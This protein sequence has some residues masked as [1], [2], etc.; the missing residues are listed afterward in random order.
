MSGW[1]QEGGVSMSLPADN[2]Q[3]LEA[4]D[5]FQSVCVTA[6]AGSGKTELLSLRVLKLLAIAERPEEILAITFTRKAAAEMHHRIIQALRNAQSGPQPEEAHKLLSWN[7]AKEVL[8]RDEH[9]GW[10]VLDNP[11]RLKIQTIDSLCAN[12]TRQMPILSNFG[13]QPTIAKDAQAHYRQA[14]R[15]LFQYLE[16]DSVL[17]EDLSIL[18]GH[19]DNDMARAERLLMTLLQGRDQWLIHIGADGNPQSAKAALEKT[20]TSVCI[21]LLSKL[22]AE[23]LPM[24]PE[25]LPL[26]DYAGCNIQWQKLNSSISNLAGILELPS[27]STETIDSWL[28]IAELFLTASNS[29]RKTINKNT[30]FPTETEDGDK[31]LA[32]QLKNQFTSHLKELENNPALTALF[33]ELRH[34]PAPQYDQQQ[35]QLLESLTRLL[36]ALVAQLTL[37]FQQHGEVDYSQISMAALQALGENTNPTELA[38]KLDYQLRHILVDEFQDTALTQYRLLERLVEGWEEL[39]VN[40]PDSPNTVFIVGDGMQS[41]YGFR[42]ANVG[43]F[44]EA[45]NN[46]I[47][48]VQLLDLHLTVNFRS[49]PEVVEWINNTFL[50]AFPRIENLARG[51]VPFEP[52]VAYS[53]PNET[54]NISL[55]GFVG[56]HARALEADSVVALVKSALETDP[57]GSIAILVRSRGHLRDILPALKAAEIT[58]NANEIDS[59]ASYGVIIDLLTLTKALFNIADRISWVALLRTPWI[60]LSNKDIFALISPNKD[61]SIY[62]VLTSD[63]PIDSL[64]RHGRERLVNIRGIVQATFESRARL[65]ARDWVEATWLALGGAASVGHHNEFR[66]VDD[67]FDLLEQYQQGELLPSLT[68]FEEAV[69]K[70]YAAP[71][72]AESQLQ[73]MTIHK[74][75]GLEFDTVILPGMARQLRSDEKSL[76]MWR[77]YI[78]TDHQSGMVISPLDAIGNDE[79]AI[80]RHLRYEKTEMDRLEN[81]RLFYVAATRAISKLHVLVTSDVDK[82]TEQPKKPSNNSLI[83]SAWSAL[84]EDVIWSGMEQAGTVD[85]EQFDFSFS[86]SESELTLK[87]LRADW[88]EPEWSFPNPLEAFYLPFDYDFADNTIELDVDILS[89]CVGTIVHW[90][91]EILVEKGIDYWTD[92]D[93]ESR[94]GWLEGLLHHHQLPNSLWSVAVARIESALNNTLNDSKGIWV[95]SGSHN[96][97]QTEL[98]L[99]VNKDNQIKQ[100]VVDR[101]FVDDKGVQWIVDYKTSTPLAHET[102]DEFIA[103]EIEQYRYQLLDYKLQLSELNSNSADESQSIIKT[104]LYFTH[105]PHWQEVEL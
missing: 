11:G 74:A 90:L 53:E 89:S 91:L 97:S 23:L 95:L 20:L 26:M 38:M 19:V 2:Q 71:D 59:L 57:Q 86:D 98:S 41:I 47:N 68:A 6:P 79:D 93:D 13:A 8:S 72:N 48:G 66:A 55:K 104:A 12:L 76:L 44:L 103:R 81:T 43:L 36:P 64:T 65:S 35:W 75:K 16:Q 96:N 22:R 70:L 14:V 9:C 101:C 92:F 7:L 69:E 50:D 85:N 4:L 54:S 87:R 40:H 45:R 84:S 77:E 78:S 25:L 49:S 61:R 100:R 83:T 17:A 94:Q 58:W 82:K 10:N 52:A 60:G 34:L 62:S 33:V 105:Y 27:V 15:N 37:V 18:L 73:V 63:K 42:Q 99:L 39:N 102:K 32:K 51:A 46:G 31:Q 21:D 3:R 80:Y 88:N 5:P 56:D 28:A 29:A 67:Y 30:G 1:T 24:A